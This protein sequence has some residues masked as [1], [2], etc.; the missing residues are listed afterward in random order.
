MADAAA[1]FTGSFVQC[2]V[3]SG[4][5]TTYFERSEHLSPP[6]FFVV[7]RSREMLS[8]LPG[9]APKHAQVT[10][11]SVCG[12]DSRRPFPCLGQ[13]G[14]RTSEPEVCQFLSASNLP[15]A[16]Q[17]A[18]SHRQSRRPMSC[19]QHWFSRRRENQFIRCVVE[20]SYTDGTTLHH[21]PQLQLGVQCRRRC[22]HARNFGCGGWPMASLAAPGVLS[23]A[24]ARIDDGNSVWQS[25][26]EPTAGR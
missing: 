7:S 17:A 10:C 20:E 26:R 6:R 5:R 18:F 24:P 23:I 22:R 14:T 16:H 19:S 9:E 3:T 11:S 12:I 8:P 1:V 21:R 2:E 4:R 25:N 15:L 13:E